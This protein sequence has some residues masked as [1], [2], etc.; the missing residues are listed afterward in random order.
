M[1]DLE[2]MH[3]FTSSTYQTLTTDPVTQNLW[4][5]GVIRMAL[6]CD[7]LMLSILSVSALHMK[8]L[9][10]TRSQEM[11]AQS[12]LYHEEASRLIVGVMEH[13]GTDRNEKFLFSVLTIFYGK[14]LGCKRVPFI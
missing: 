3:H 11:Q 12:V 4:R 13:E 5:T 8:H 6:S 14:Y 1:V 7:Y 10:P 9:N 2:L